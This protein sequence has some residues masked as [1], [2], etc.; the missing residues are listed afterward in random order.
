MENV[1]NADYPTGFVLWRGPSV[2]D[3]APIVVIATLNSRN[4]KTG[5]MIQ[6]WIMRED[7]E[8]H[9][10]QQTGQDESVCGNCPQRPSA[11]G[12]CYVATA[13]A[14]LAVWRAYHDGK[15]PYLSDEGDIS[16][17]AGAVGASVRAGSY[18]DPA[19][20]PMH[21]WEHLG[22]R[23][24]YTHQWRSYP[25]LRGLVMAS[26]DSVDE[27]AEAV[28]A[29]WRY[30]RVRP[31][32]APL[33]AGEIDCPSERGVKCIDCGLC[34]GTRLGAKSVSIEEHGFRVKSSKRSLPVLAAA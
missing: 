21:V 31:A 11:G 9:T 4:R 23:T 6:T 5:K 22:V 27:A 25:G 18:G 16:E 24:G 30:F 19:A 1:E 28:A 2:L 13:Q 8:P 10:A 34:S 20:V 17:L 15:Y 33:L 12:A 29:G 3:G 7:V 14:P 32:G 26:V